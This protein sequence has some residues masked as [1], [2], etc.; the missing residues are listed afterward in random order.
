MINKKI[1]K[2]KQCTSNYNVHFLQK[3]RFILGIFGRFSFFFLLTF[4]VISP[5]PPPLPPPPQN[6]ANN[7]N[8][9]N[10][11]IFNTNSTRPKYHV[12]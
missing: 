6:G 12:S 11:R 1:K 4:P 9:N 2:K 5:S 7:N 3:R 10:N 8:N